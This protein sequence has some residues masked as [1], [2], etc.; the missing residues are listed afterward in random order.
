MTKS[1][2]VAVIGGQRARPTEPNT[3]ADAEDEA[4]RRHRES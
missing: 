1:T 3:P 4:A 2:A